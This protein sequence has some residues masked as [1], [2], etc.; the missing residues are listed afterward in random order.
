MTPGRVEN[1]FREHRGR[2]ERVVTRILGDPDEAGDIVAECFV[3]LLKADLAEELILPWLM[4]CARNRA[5]NRKRDRDRARNHARQLPRPESQ[6]EDNPAIDDLRAAALVSHALAVLAPR[7]R[8]VVVMRIFED[9]P[10]HEAAEAL[11]TTVARASVILHRALRRV[12]REVVR[13][14]A[15]HHSASPSCT[16][17]LARQA[18]GGTLRP[19]AG[20]GPCAAVADEIAALSAQGLLP[21]F[22]LAAARPLTEILVRATERFVPRLPA[23][24][25][26]AVIAL[27]ITTVLS[28]GSGVPTA[29]I[30]VPSTAAKESPPGLAQIEPRIALPALVRPTPS[31]EPVVR[32]GDEGGD[33]G[34]PFLPASP[35]LPPPPLPLPLRLPDPPWDFDKPWLDL[36]SFEMTVRRG[37]DGKSSALLVRWESAERLREKSAFQLLFFFPESKDCNGVVDYEDLGR[38]VMGDHSPHAR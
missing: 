26:E 34:N 22:A 13:Q 7:D 20:C 3:A 16:R 14:L 37:A 12:R 18:F 15:N 24:L 25:P 6:G 29:R 33:D 21:P 23:R 2:L 30:L 4:T 1:A 35:S 28:I 36:R 17:T 31:L 27:L 10:A 19:H 9:Q 11:G 5:L 32:L 38:T 8:S